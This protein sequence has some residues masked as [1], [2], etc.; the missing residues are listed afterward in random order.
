MFALWRPG[1]LGVPRLIAAL[2]GGHF[3]AYAGNGVIAEADFL[4]TVNLVETFSVQG[5][6]DYF[7]GNHGAEVKWS[8]ETEPEGL[9]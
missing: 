2:R 9:L 1:F 6:T 7:S 3:N 4:A 8:R 5:S